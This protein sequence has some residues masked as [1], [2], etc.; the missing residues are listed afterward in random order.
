MKFELGET[1]RD[2]ITFFQGVALARTEY[3]T[4]CDHYGLCSRELKDNVPMDWQWFDET[5]LVRVESA[6]KIEREER[7]PTSGPQPHAPQM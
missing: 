5:R 6:A 7:K 2:K 4:G 1:L 3:F